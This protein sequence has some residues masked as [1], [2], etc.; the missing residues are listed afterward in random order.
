MKHVFNPY[1]SH[2]FFKL[3]D[4]LP[5]QLVWAK[6][7]SNNSQMWTE[8]FFRGGKVRLY[9]IYF[10]RI[11]NICLGHPSLFLKLRPPCSCLKPT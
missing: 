5:V 4:Q 6:Q 1:N 8:G 11:S 3:I 9:H 10:E 7:V 2:I